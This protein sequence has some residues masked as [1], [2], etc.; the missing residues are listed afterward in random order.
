M[1]SIEGALTE[2]IKK[3]NGE[4]KVAAAEAYRVDSY[5][6][7]VEHVAKLAYMNKD[8]LLFF[9]GQNIDYRNKAGS[10]TFY[11]SIYRGDHVPRQEI[12]YRF[13]V[14]QGASRNLSEEFTQRGLPGAPELRRKRHIQ[15][16][17]LQHYEVCNTPLL[18][19]THSLQVACS[20]AQEGNEG[21]WAYIAV[22]GLPYITNRISINSEH[23]LVNV[24]LLSICP[25]H[26]LR[27]YFQDGYLAG[28]ED[29]SDEYD[30]KSELD[31]NNRLI[32]KF[33]FP[34]EQSFWGSSFNPIP[35]EALY[36]ID[37]EVLALCKDV[38]NRAER[39]LESG[40]VGEFLKLWG[41]FERYVLEIAGPETRRPTARDAINALSKSGRINENLAPEFN[42]VR[43]FR[44]ELVHHP[45]KIKTTDVRHYMQIV[46]H[47]MAELKGQG[48]TS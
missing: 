6:E 11:P 26:A 39:D 13:D 19:F 31:F 33:C 1:R 21:A 7:L 36:P 29:V 8:N 27:P 44:N 22:F 5:R 16:S 2:E 43:R 4:R 28:T 34:N 9:R 48:R 46:S 45:D 35:G 32:A 10:S 12:R 18:D 3:Q 24:R 42:R 40:T 25:P 38:K 23:D 37:D 47:L 20:F 14:L 17:V 30:N 41:E 15:W